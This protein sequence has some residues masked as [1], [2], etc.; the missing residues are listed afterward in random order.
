MAHNR[1]ITVAH[2][3]DADDAFMFYALTTGKIC[4]PDFEI[5]HVLKSI[6]ELNEAAKQ[7]VYDMSALS[8]A[9][10]PLV[11]DKY[12]L[13]PC[14]ACMG[15]RRGP[16]L[17]SSQEYSLDALDKITIA[18]P[19]RLTTA[20]LVLKIL[21]PKVQVVELPFDQIVDAIT[22]GKVDAGLIIHE[23]QLTHENSG[24]K[25]IVDLGEWWHNQTGLPL[26]LGG[27]VIKKDLPSQIAATITSLFQQSIKYA[28]THRDEA[29]TYAL[30]YARGMPLDQAAQFI[31]T[32]VNDFTIDYGETGNQ[33]LA[34]L[35]NRAFSC[36][37]I[38]R[39]VQIEFAQQETTNET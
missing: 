35:F 37:A 12:A 2:T 18:I 19:G 7:G 29:A 38:N 3:P 21:E 9:A 8:F 26:P 22:T 33:A 13:M 30:R 20:F 10:Y 16:M 6:Q 25:K 34:A 32:Y 11:A 1:T 28:L 5:V 15:F 17:L 4:S 14:G 31:G 27:N 23:A 39:P 36:S 24:L